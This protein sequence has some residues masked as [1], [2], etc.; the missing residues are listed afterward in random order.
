M[1]IDREA[2]EASL[3]RLDE[4]AV[5]ELDTSGVLTEVVQAAKRLL[6]VT[7][8]GLMIVDTGHT[9]R[10]VAASDAAGRALEDA[11][12]QT[13]EGPC[14]TSF[15]LDRPITLADVEIDERWPALRSLVKET[16]IRA[17]LAVPVRL[18]GAPVG[19]LDVYRDHPH[20]WAD[21][22]IAVLLGYARVVENLLAA[23][24]AAH[25]GG[26]VVR[27]L[28]FAL[29]YRVSIERAI[30]FVMASDR[31]D[32]VTAFNRL[33]AKARSSRRK[34]GEIAEE[35]LRGEPLA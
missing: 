13:G 4:I 35:T 28:Q 8:V 15:V 9:L 34:I 11:Q 33:R 16:K 25:R 29:D 24:A 22:D 3:R 2:L 23:S 12:E 32:A 18:G 10:Q 31:V 17:I 1:G 5:G 26:E 7:G 6:P 19:T 14:V 27:Q 21:D 20:D 30:G